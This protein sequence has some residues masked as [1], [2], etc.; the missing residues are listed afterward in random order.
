MDKDKILGTISNNTRIREPDRDIIKD[1]REDP[2]W[3]KYIEED[4]EDYF[5]NGFCSA[6]GVVWP[7]G[8]G[9]VEKLKL[10]LKWDHLPYRQDG[11]YILS[12]GCGQPW[13]PSFGKITFAEIRKWEEPITKKTA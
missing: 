1:L 9:V 10:A 7:K 13:C 12:D 6:C 11:E 3:K 5:I 8:Y 4:V 2:E